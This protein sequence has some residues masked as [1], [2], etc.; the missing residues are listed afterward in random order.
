[1]LSHPAH[2]YAKGLVAA[3]PRITAAQAAGFVVDA[4]RVDGI[5]KGLRQADWPSDPWQAL[6]RLAMGV[7]RACAAR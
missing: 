4:H 1:M 5:V 2:P 6:H 3:L 7:C